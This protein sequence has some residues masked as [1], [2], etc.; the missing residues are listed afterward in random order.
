LPLLRAD[1]EHILRVSDTGPG[2]SA[3]ERDAVLRRF[4][5]SD[6]LRSVSGLGLGLNLVAAIVKLHE[7]RLTIHPGA[8]CVIE[9]ASPDRHDDRAS[10]SL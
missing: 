10:G 4:Y 3:E 2:I 7:F 6:K 9:I 8:G 5:R 1:G